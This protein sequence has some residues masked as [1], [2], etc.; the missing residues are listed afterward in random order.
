MNFQEWVGRML[1]HDNV[2]SIESVE[3]SF[4][5]N[6]AHRP[7]LVLVGCIVLAIA[8]ALFYS[9]YQ[10]TNR[11]RTRAFLTVLRAAARAAAGDPG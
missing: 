5:A 9:R 8:A 11:H 7:V 1:G 10:P 4:A 3:P 2:R 6:W